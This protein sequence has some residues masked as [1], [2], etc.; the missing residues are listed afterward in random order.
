MGVWNHQSIPP[1]PRLT[2]AAS[3]PEL[4]RASLES[5]GKIEE[6]VDLYNNS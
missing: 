5:D 2:A 4:F 6:S 3:A 1:P